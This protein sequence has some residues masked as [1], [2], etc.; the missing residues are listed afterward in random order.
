MREGN[1]NVMASNNAAFGGTM[2]GFKLDGD[3]SSEEDIDAI[4]PYMR[5][6]YPTRI[7][8]KRKKITT[9]QK[10]NLSWTKAFFT[11]QM[12]TNDIDFLFSCLFLGALIIILGAL[13]AV[14]SY[15]GSVIMFAFTILHVVLL[16]ISMLGYVLANRR[17]TNRERILQAS[18]F[19]ILYISSI[20]YMIIAYDIGLLS[21]ENGELNPE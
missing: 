1:N 8:K 9:L 3:E 7:D 15:K 19:L 17:I 5:A 18:A 21:K 12:R 16:C 10:R 4:P 2:M 20:V 13:G 14:Y 6:Y 11:S